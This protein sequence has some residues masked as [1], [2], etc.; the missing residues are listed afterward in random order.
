MDGKVFAEQTH[1]V[2]LSRHGAGIVLQHKLAP[3]QEMI[4]RRQ[5]TNKEAAVRIVRVPGAQPDNHTYGLAFVNSN[6]NIWDV[7]FP[8]L[9][10]FEKMAVQSLFECTRCKV[11]ETVDG[12]DHELEGIAGNKDVVRPCN[13]CGFPTT[14]TRVLGSEGNINITQKPGAHAPEVT[15][16]GAQ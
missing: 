14:W 16:S 4:I 11:R 10:E 2:E 12:S 3:E 13:R 1:T 9:S 15:I 8:P 5:D 7:E 6:T